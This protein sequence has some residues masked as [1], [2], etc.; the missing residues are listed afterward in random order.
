M[1]RLF[2]NTGGLKADQIR[3]LEKLYRRRIPPELVITVELAKEISSLSNELRRQIGLLINRA[4]KITCVIVGNHSKIV[5]P[6]ISEYRIAPGRLRGLRCLHTHLNNEPLTND[7]LTDLALLRLDLMGVITTEV[8]SRPPK[9]YLSHILPN[10]TEDQPYRR[11][12][13]LYANELNIGCLD[14]IKA[15]ESELAHVRELQ[16]GGKRKER[17]LLVSV[18][19]DPGHIAQNAM[20]ELEEL[21]IS[22]GIEGV[23]I[24][25][26]HRQSIDSRF[27]MGRGKLEELA[28]TALN[29]GAT[30]IIFDQ[31]LNPSQI[32]S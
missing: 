6:D 28:L 9:V 5:I 23:G 31:E 12:Q 4:G 32:R 10:Q 16:P 24:I 20:A 26:Q 8:D 17:A 29:R 11:L 19:R 25:Y 27:L 3:R 2:G 21:A 7:D 1:K 22:S 13:P 15:L 14:L 18:T 30:L